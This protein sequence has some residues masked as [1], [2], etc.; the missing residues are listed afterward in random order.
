VGDHDEMTHSN[1]KLG[2]HRAEVSGGLGERRAVILSFWGGQ[3][4]RHW[5]VRC[6]H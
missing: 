4:V 2:E 3:T 5:R 6:S 1:I